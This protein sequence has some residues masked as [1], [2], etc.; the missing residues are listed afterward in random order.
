[1]TESLSK[2]ILL[3]FR[4]SNNWRIMQSNSSDG[5]GPAKT[6]AIVAQTS[7]RL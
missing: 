1:M 7:S 4:R 5:G 3:A 2:L 6:R